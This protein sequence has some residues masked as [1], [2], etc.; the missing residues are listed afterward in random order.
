MLLTSTLLLSLSALF[1]AYIATLGLVNLLPKLAVM[2]MPNERS[3]HVL[4]TP[5][6]GGLAVVVAVVGFLMVAGVRMEMVAAFLIVAMVSMIDDVKGLPASKR[7]AMHLVCALLASS[8]IEGQVFQ[9]LLPYWADK[10]ALAVVWAGFMNF[11]NFMDGIDE[12]T[13]TQ[14][15]SLCAGV[16][17]LLFSVTQVPKF[18][19]VDAMIIAAGTLG[20]WFFNRHP[21]R[22]FLGDVGSVTLGFV[23]GYLLVHLAERGLWMAALIL[24]AYYMIDAGLTLL[25]R[26]IAGKR[27]WEAHSEHGYQCAVRAYGNP[28]K[29]VTQI[30]AINIVLIV[31][32]VTST[33]SKV[34]GLAAL[35]AAYWLTFLFWMHLRTQKVIIQPV[36]PEII[37]P[38]H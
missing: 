28:R 1:F 8:L 6:G 18:L 15:F 12:I 9:G 4:P 19:G 20:F 24:P 36:V 7:L 22:I 2:D 33:V 11:Y 14:T 13:T 29:V 25:L 32:A 16:V 21:A 38:V 26:L 30:A 34:Y 35:E 27:I 31:L 10:V 3:N 5:R 23:T 37:P 17:A